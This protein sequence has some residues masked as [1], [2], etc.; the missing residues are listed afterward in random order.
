MFLSYNL[1]LAG[2]PLYNNTVVLI[3]VIVRVTV[4]FRKTVVGD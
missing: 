1:N 3:N 2:K 4:V